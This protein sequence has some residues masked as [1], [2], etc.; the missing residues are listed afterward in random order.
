MWRVSIFISAHPFGLREIERT[1]TRHF[2]PGYKRVTSLWDESLTDVLRRPTR[3]GLGHAG[4]G[5]RW[6][7]LSVVGGFEGVHLVAAGR[8]G[9]D[10]ASRH[11]VGQFG[12]GAAVAQAGDALIVGGGD[13]W[14]LLEQFEE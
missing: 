13:E 4:G 7:L 14:L 10:D 12:I 8:I 1:T 9:H 5:G 3:W 2:V 11:K 6:E